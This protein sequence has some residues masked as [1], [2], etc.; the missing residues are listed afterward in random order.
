MKN[1]HLSSLV[2]PVSTPPI[3][4]AAEWARNRL[5]NRELLNLSQAVPSYA[6]AEELRA[7]IARL[8]MLPE[9]GLYTAIRGND[10]LRTGLAAHMSKDYGAELKAGDVTIT[11][12]CNQAFCA[13]L[14]AL[15]ER[16]D[17]VI[18]PSPYYFNHQM[19]LAMLGIDIR[20]IKAF[21]EGRAFPSPEEAASLIDSGTRAIILCTPN[22]PTGAIYPPEIIAQFYELAASRG[23]ALVIDETYK[24]FRDGRQP[25]HDIFTRR[26]WRDTF[27]QLYSFSKIYAMTG[28]RAGSIIAGPAVSEQMEKILDC[29]A[30]CTPA[31]SQGAALYGLQHLD[32]WASEKVSMMS[33]RRAALLDAFKAPGL[34]YTL[35]SSGAYFAYV[36]HPFAGTPSKQVAQRLAR[37]HDVLCLPGSMFGPGQEDHLRFAFA[38]VPAEAMATLAERLLESQR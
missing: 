13:A 26:G 38:N 7:E 20:G 24:D 2:T 27:V 5:S 3:A 9:I 8:A 21:G 29:M 14:M 18:L 12:G 28:Y 25:P 11:A 32:N 35:E 31:I 1:L 30:I 17:N 16:G 36:R 15:A 22:N 33:E 34:R 6:P 23:I 37:E 10:D 4:E 19:W